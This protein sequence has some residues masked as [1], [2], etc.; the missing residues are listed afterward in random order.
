MYSV[1]EKRGVRIHAVRLHFDYIS[2]AVHHSELLVCRAL[3]R[4]YIIDELTDTCLKT[5][6]IT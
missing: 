6:R 1:L 5:Q 3:K 4:C 2:E